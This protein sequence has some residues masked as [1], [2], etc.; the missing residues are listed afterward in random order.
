MAE[1][2]MKKLSVHIDRKAVD[3]YCEERIARWA[4]EF[5][6]KSIQEIACKNFREWMGY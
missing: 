2:L 1:K 3:T 6:D 5:N 4:V